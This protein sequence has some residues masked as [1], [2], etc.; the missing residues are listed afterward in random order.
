MA[1]QSR[2]YTIIEERLDGT[3]AELIAARRP[4]TSWRDI[5][6]EVTEKTGVPVSDETL[7]LWF[8][9]RITVETTVRVA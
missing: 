6:D 2:L 3:L 9:D 4:S 7:R 8:A 1:K 5:A